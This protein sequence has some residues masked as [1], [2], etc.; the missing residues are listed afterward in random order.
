MENLYKVVKIEGKGFTSIAVQDIEIGTLILREKFQCVP[1]LSSS[2]AT[3]IESFLAMSKK[4]Q[5]EFLKLWNKFSHS[6]SLG[7]ELKYDYLDWKRS[8]QRYSAQFK[9]DSNFILNIFCIYHTNAFSDGSLAIETSKFN[10]SCSPNADFHRKSCTTNEVEIRTTT[11]V[12]KGDEIS[13]NWYDEHPEISMNNV[14]D[15]QLFLLRNWGFICSCELCQEE[16]ETTNQNDEVYE[17]FQILKE[18]TGKLN[19]M[20]ANCKTNDEKLENIL[21]VISCYNRMYELAS[22]KKTSK[23]FVSD[24]I[25]R[26]FLVGKGGYILAKMNSNSAKMERFNKECIK[27]ANVGFQIAKMCYGN[28]SEVVTTWQERY[29]EQ[30]NIFYTDCSPS[31]QADVNCESE[32]ESAH[33]LKITWHDLYKKILRRKNIKK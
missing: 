33:S 21:K 11:I 10:H 29:Q 31:P 24:I 25:N 1:S 5:E 14:K 12:K 8:A 32:S 23:L 2:R 28:D 22:N 7:E 19:E 20:L 3:I 16:E 9:I 17:E 6:D 18:E 27:L 15:R 30:Q 4:N 26:S 13:I